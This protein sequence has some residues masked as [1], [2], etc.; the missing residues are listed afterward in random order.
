MAATCHVVCLG[1]RCSSDSCEIPTE[2]GRWLWLQ[3]Y[4][5]QEQQTKWI[6][7]LSGPPADLELTQAWD[8]SQDKHQRG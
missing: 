8:P 3:E 6:T 2:G 5:D 1:A 7:E 4:P